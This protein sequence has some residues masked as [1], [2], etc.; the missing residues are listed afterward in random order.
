[1]K[2]GTNP[3]T[4][5][6]AAICLVAC[7]ENKVV[8]TP[9]IPVFNDPDPA[10]WTLNSDSME[11]GTKDFYTFDIL[12]DSVS[13]SQK[14]HTDPSK[15]QYV[16]NTPFEDVINITF[17]GNQATAECENT[18]DFT[19]QTN[20][21]HVT[22]NTT[23]D[24][25][26]SL[27]GKSDNGSLKIVGN[28]KVRINLN[29]VDLK[30]SHGPSIENQSKEQCFLVTD[31][32]SVLSDDSLYA[33]PVDSI[34]PKGCICSKGNL[35]ISGQAPLK[36]IA[37]GADAIHSSK[38]IFIRRA[39]D[40]DIVS[41]AADAI[42]AKENVM[43]EG[44]KLNINSTG[45]GGH[46]IAASKEV[47]IASGRTTIIS[48]TGRSDNGK[49]TRCIKSD[50]LINITGG[51]V[52]IKDTSLG[53]KGIRAGHKVLIKNCM[54]DV[55]TSGG[56]DMRYASKNRGIQ[57][58][59]EIEI[60]SSRVRVRCKNGKCEALSSHLKIIIN[61]SLC[62]LQA[63]DDA[64]SAGVVHKADI[65]V[66]NS[67][68]LADAGMDGFDSNGTIHINSG[69]IY[70]VGLGH[71][72]RGFDCDTHE[73][74]IG[75]E[76]II[77]SLGQ[78]T[79]PPTANLL[80]HPAFYAMRPLEDTEFCLSTTGNNDNLVSVTRPTFKFRNT[81]FTA[82]ISVPELREGVSYDFCRTASIKP[83]HTF[84]NI[85][86]GGTAD[87][88]QVTETQIFKKGYNNL[89]PPKPKTTPLNQ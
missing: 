83:K 33:E 46:G 56:D 15:P 9:P 37:R 55:L 54:V 23:K 28:N 6:I 47:T 64:I 4:I 13:F 2:L 48:N 78:I 61:N 14:L 19:I 57:G 27:T 18:S 3:I 75:P 66:T 67:H 34:N 40:I 11:L 12:R 1:M 41:T 63:N 38:D 8:E 21:A 43:I 62:E 69:I 74:L 87:N 72:C 68:I 5:A 24:V 42:K 84:H 70:A 29:G 52:R 88:K 25:A 59:D 31:S 7:N 51:V 79:S 60:E 85:S 39:T 45:A 80:S 20:G 86:I 22:I 65:E 89:V 49:N 10:V 35:Y 53:G 16:E 30:N 36:I 50:S 76:A 77:V 58:A 81:G 26:C 32:I 17:N 44:G 71:S 73:F 82:L